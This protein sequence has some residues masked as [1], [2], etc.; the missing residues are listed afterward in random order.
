M[1]KHALLLT[2]T[3][4]FL[5]FAP[6]L[7]AADADPIAL[8]DKTWVLVASALVFM[9][10]IGFLFLEGGLVRSKNS[11]NVAQK[12]LVDLVVSVALFGIIGYM[13]MFGADLFGFIGM[14]GNLMLFSGDSEAALS[15]LIFQA[16]FCGT[17]ATIVSGAV[18]ERLTFSA[19]LVLVAVI[20]AL[21][22]PIFGHWA[23]G[24]LLFPGNTAWLADLGFIDFAGSTVVHSIGAWSGLAAVVIMGPRIGRF[25]EDGTVGR[26]AS[27]NTVLASAGTLILFIGWFGFNGGSALTMDAPVGHIILNTLAAG[28]FGGLSGTFLSRMKEGI[29]RPEGLINGV[30]GGLVAVTAGCMVLTTQGALLVGLV[31]GMVAVSGVWLLLKL[32]IDDPVGAIPVH[33][34][35]GVFGTIALALLAPEQHLAA[36]SRFAQIGVQML[37]A[38]AAFVWAFGGVW[39]VLKLLSSVMPLRVTAEQELAGLNTAEH[40]ETLGTGRLQELLMELAVGDADLSARLEV[41]RGDEAG[42]LADLFNRLMARLEQDNI[43]RRFLDDQNRDADTVRRNADARRQES[44]QEIIAKIAEVIAAVQDKRLN[45]RVDLGAQMGTLKSIG[46]GVNGLLDTLSGLIRSIGSSVDDLSGAAEQQATGSRQLAVSAN[47]Q[48]QQMAS[49]RQSLGGFQADSNSISTATQGATTAVGEAVAASRS[50]Q[51]AA[52]VAVDA[53]NRMEVT[54]AEALKIIDHINEIA[55]QT[56]ILA[57][58][59]AIEASSAGKAGQSFGVIAT[60]VRGLASQVGSLA[61]EAGKLLNSSMETVQE[62]VKA[63]SKASTTL[64]GVSERAERGMRSVAEI[65][66]TAKRQSAQC[67]DLMDAIDRIGK[68]IDETAVMA[69]KTHSVANG[70]AETTDGLRREVAGYDIEPQQP[71]SLTRK[72]A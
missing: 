42:E 33:G 72:S 25:L 21:V 5:A 17:A 61:D 59:A 58:N 4:L 50:S 56:N 7:H 55:F 39:I 35:A 38:G 28:V 32:K 12:N 49:L 48:H 34:F 62:S 40:G 36:G 29:W 44:E 68:S 8:I 46:D 1:R 3:F 6:P 52:A 66:E 27:H 57:I 51:D 10:Q 53:V 23:W 13:F 9:M 22:Y 16:M 43:R 30:L 41:D 54:A 71:A 19:Y 63:I 60:E 67:N 65:A 15:F 11:I 18:A 45:N 26:I 24:K 47:Q 2:N 70:L 14:D 69:E 31:G 37:G 64:D 20:A